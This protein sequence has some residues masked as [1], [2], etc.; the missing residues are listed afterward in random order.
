M[1]KEEKLN[2][3]DAITKLEVIVR[4]MESGNLAL[5]ES[6]KAYEEGMK[7]VRFCEKELGKYEKLLSGVAERRRNAAGIVDGEEDL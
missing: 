5:E 6:V 3:E 7:L 4:Q 1:G 2:Y